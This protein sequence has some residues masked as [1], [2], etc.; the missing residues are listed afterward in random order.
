MRRWVAL[1]MWAVIM[2]A[3][4]AQV[5][6]QDAVDWQQK[7]V[8][9][10]LYLRGLWRENTLA[11]D[12][13]GKPVKS[14]TPGSLTLSGVDVKSVN[15]KGRR[16]T[17]LAERAALVADADGVLQRATPSS[18]TLIVGS[19]LPKDKRYFKAKE[20]MKITIDADAAGGFDTAIHA[21]FAN[22]LAELATS[23]PPYWSCYAEGYFKQALP[24]AAAQKAVQDCVLRKDLSDV[25]GELVEGDFVAPR[26][27]S[28]EKPQFPAEAAELGA[29]GVIHLH[30]TVTR[31]GASAGFQVVQA[32]G[33]G[34]EEP[35]LMYLYQAKFEPGTKDGFPVNADYEA[36]Y[37]FETT[38]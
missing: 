29:S 20:E 34:V 4:R 36:K 12:A 33:A 31:K 23:V 6:A 38:K 1:L 28:S 19:L 14:A 24:I 27:V 16:L 2:V 32:L 13:A 30:C 10:P 22:G 35:L 9:R 7:L 5:Y 37:E 3:G 21:V 15:V 25:K 26:M 8:G 11:F 17:I 18:S